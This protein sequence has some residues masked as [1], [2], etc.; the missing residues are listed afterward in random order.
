MFPGNFDAAAAEAVT[1]VPA[2]LPALTRL[3]DASLVVAEHTP[4]GSATD[5]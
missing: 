2:V 4:E 5:S 1:A 3:A